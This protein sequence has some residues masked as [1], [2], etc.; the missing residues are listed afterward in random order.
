V[1]G[2]SFFTSG[3]FTQ[4]FNISSGTTIMTMTLADFGTVS[5]GTIPAGTLIPV[6]WNFTTAANSGAAIT[7]WNLGFELGSSPGFT[8]DGAV[9]GS[10]SGAGTFSGSS[11]LTVSNNIV[12][13]STLYETVVLTLNLNGNFGFIQITVPTNTTFDFQSVAASAVPEPASVGLIGAGLAFFGA[14]LR[15][16]RKP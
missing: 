7:S 9:S 4:G 15:R 3:G 16:R 13:G 11:V 12:S 6:A 8:N 10:G 2:L 5:G 1:Q 14:L